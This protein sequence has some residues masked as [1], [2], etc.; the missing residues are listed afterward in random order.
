MD[1]LVFLESLGFTPL[2]IILVVMVYFLGTAA[3]VFPKLWKH[4]EEKEEVPDWAL[5]LQSH[6]NETTSELLHE[7][8]SGVVK[9]DERGEK[10]CRKLDDILNDLDEMKE[11]DI[12][13]R[14][15]ARSFMREQSKK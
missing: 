1:Y 3:G 12:E 13:W 10:G 4:E 6:F 9:L 15:E 11:S 7:I 8:H 5:K 2:N 14:A